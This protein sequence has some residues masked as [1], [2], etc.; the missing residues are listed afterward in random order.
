MSL[1]LP[2]EGNAIALTCSV[3]PLCISLFRLKWLHVLTG[4]ACTRVNARCDFH[5]VS[6]SVNIPTLVCSEHLQLLSL[7]SAPPTSQLS[8]PASHSLYL[9]A[10]I[11]LWL[12]HRKGKRLTSTQREREVEKDS[13]V[14][15]SRT[16]SKINWMT[17][18]L[19]DLRRCESESARSFS[20]RVTFTHMCNRWLPVWQKGVIKAKLRGSIYRSGLFNCQGQQTVV[21]HSS[22]MSDLPFSKKS[23][24]VICRNASLGHMLCRE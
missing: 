19:F 4:P 9:S 7:S 1:D 5:S 12:K 23:N 11:F 17:A 14:W 16:A 22:F 3:F 8:L 2:S 24:L 15:W 6:N 21:S 10:P 18:E 20:R 13:G